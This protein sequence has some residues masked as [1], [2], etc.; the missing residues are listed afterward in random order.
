MSLFAGLASGSGLLFSSVLVSGGSKLGGPLGLVICAALAYYFL[1]MYLETK[2][3]MAGGIT[4]L[5]AVLGI[6]YTKSLF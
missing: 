3:P 4:A 1:P 5:S 6:L 2:K